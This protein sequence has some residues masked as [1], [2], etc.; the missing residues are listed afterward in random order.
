MRSDPNAVGKGGLGFAPARPGPLDL[1]SVCEAGPG[2]TAMGGL[3]FVYPSPESL[4]LA[5][6]R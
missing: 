1:T 2:A 6:N 4:R 5:S 3:G